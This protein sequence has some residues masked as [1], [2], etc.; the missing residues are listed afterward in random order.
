MV[1]EENAASLAGQMNLILGRYEA[2]RNEGAGSPGHKMDHG[3][4][5][6]QQ[7]LGQA[8]FQPERTVA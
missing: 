2:A 4:S 6:D 3:D 5:K 8:P 7:K 1:T